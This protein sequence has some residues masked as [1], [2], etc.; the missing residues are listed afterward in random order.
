MSLLDR[1]A[2]KPS[3]LARAE[4]RRLS[5]PVGEH[6][7]TEFAQFLTPAP[8]ADFLA[9]LF[10]FSTLENAS[11]LD[12]GTGAG[13]LSAAVADR[14]VQEGVGRLSVTG[15]EIDDLMRPTLSETF[16][17]LRDAG[18][19]AEVVAEDFVQWSSKQIDSLGSGT[20]LESRFDMAIMNPPYYKI[21]ARSIERRVLSRLGVEVGNIYAGFVALAVRML[22]ENGQIVAITPR[23]FANG[24]YF[25][26]FR[27]DLLRSMSLKRI[28][29]YDSRDLAFSGDDVLQENV[30]FHAVRND[31]KGKVT[32]SSSFGPG[33]AELTRMVDHD[34]VVRPDD[35]ESFIHLT[36]DDLDANIAE[37]FATLPATLPELGVAVSTG[38]V[39]DFRSRDFLRQMPSANENT[40]P[41]VYPAHFFSGSIRWPISPGRK[42]NAIVR[43]PSTESLMLPNG[44]YVLVKR[45]TSKEERR[46]VVAVVSDSESLPGDVVAFENHLNV[47]HIQNG[48]LELEFARGLAAFLNSTLLDLHFRQWSGHTQVNATDLRSLRYPRNEQLISLGRAVGESSL[49]QEK[50]D[51]LVTAHIQELDHPGDSDPLMTHQ[52]IQEAQAVLKALGLP[53]PQT[54]ERSA[55]TLLALLNL[56][57]NRSWSDIE[58]PLMGITPMMQFMAQEYG[59]RYAPNS[60]E[61]V[62]RQSIHQFV[63]AGVALINP[64]DSGRPTN[65]GDTVYQVPPILIEVLKTYASDDWDE[66]I[67]KWRSS[68]PVLV[69]RWERERAMSMIPVTLP[70]GTEVTLSA[71]GQN[72]LIKEVVHEF[73]PRFAPGSQVLYVG[74]AGD[75]FAVWKHEELSKLNVE[76]DEHG[77]M[78]DVVVH[79][80]ERGWLLLIE[81]VTSHGPMDAKRREELSQLFKGSTAGLV[82][83]TAFLDKKT[84]AKYLPVI[85][86]E[87]EVWMSEA[88]THLIHFNG[89]RFLGP[90]DE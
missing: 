52:R 64:D 57:A 90:Y 82:Y 8:V 86:W 28:H 53:K 6:A 56:T 72:P 39:V 66:S 46:R 54:N 7:R 49:A 35:E 21:G 30:I 59:K 51:Q 17:D 69:E 3:L 4:S 20:N 88:P 62:R 43:A 10:D 78:P 81:A 37:R 22:N 48:P 79:D 42:C 2:V 32:I 67:A 29:V 71:G 11:L 38:R 19:D 87:T 34:D 47:F 84:L 9:S 16:S 15:V 5:T 23:S 85:S 61:T 31:R 75:K 12:P 27:K 44:P 60:R 73:C 80:P 55:L 50:I 45:F 40:A 65:S 83:V 89:S 18:I 41:L 77:K 68:A 70:D 13:S 24:P 63:A 36:R 74:D 33:D 1:R 76:V 26:A 14:W 25:K 58:S